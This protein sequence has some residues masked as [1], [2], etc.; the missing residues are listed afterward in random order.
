MPLLISRNDITKIAA[1]AIVNAANNT[2]LG[3]GG[4]GSFDP[5]KKTRKPLEKSAKPG[6]WRKRKAERQQLAWMHQ[7]P[8]R[9]TRECP[10]PP[11]GS[12]A[13][14][15][16]EAFQFRHHSLMFPCISYNPQALGRYEPTVV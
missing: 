2:L 15:S 5:V 10:S 7:N 9:I 14:P 4:V 12:V 1:D 11:F 16:Y 3:G 8:L 6:V 13:S